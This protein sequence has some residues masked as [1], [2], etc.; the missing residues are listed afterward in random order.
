[1]QD[2]KLKLEN[3]E[4]A[5]SGDV[6]T[7]GRTPDNAVSFPSDSNVSRYHAEIELRGGDHYL[8]DLNSSN[9]TSVN[10]NAVKG[11]VRLEPG[12]KLLFGG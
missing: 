12:D 4:I 10:G 2:A 5:L 3:S 8:I 1:M 6:T 11:E 9:G 7:I